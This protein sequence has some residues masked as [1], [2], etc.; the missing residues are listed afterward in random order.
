MLSFVKKFVYNNGSRKSIFGG[1]TMHYHTII[2][3]A[4]PAG[5]FAAQ[6]LGQNRKSVLI[7]E[8][9]P[10]AGRK[11]LISGAGQCNFTHAGPIEDFLMCY[12]DQGKF[13]KKALYSWTNLDTMRF[14]EEMNVPYQIYPNQ[15][16]FPKS[17]K[18][19]EVL[20]A[21]LRACQMGNV[22]IEY[23][24]T[25]TQLEVYDGIFA[26][27]TQEGKRY[28][29][30]HVILATGGK[31]YAQLGSDGLGYELAK[32]LGHTVISPHPALTD[33]RL[34]ASPYK[35]I[36]GIAVQN[37]ALTIWRDQ[38]K[39]YSNV[40]DLL[41]THKGISGPVIINSSRWMKENDSLTINLLHPST[42]EEI[43]DYF[44]NCL[45]QRGKEEVITFLKTLKL[46]KN[47]LQILCQQINLDEHTPCAQVNRKTR[48][49]LVTILTKCP[50]KVDQLGGFH[51]A[52]VTAGGVH[53][54]EVNPTTMESRKQKGLY[55]VGE[56]LDVD[57]IT[58]GYNI[59]AAFSTAYLCAKHLIDK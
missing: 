25:V 11:L 3:G 18:S 39:V 44:S 23:E 32:R 10:R 21:L 31:S 38:K 51:I 47:L 5:L 4:G 24:Q 26:I 46:P 27:E 22:T 7:L 49:A 58:G 6:M 15:K 36:S 9:N 34:N 45:A 52:M 35:S 13:I 14:F 41:F 54:K 29:S 40:G 56:V 28:F 53:L 48:E 33:V 2:I 20:A 12:H 17:M 37:V 42:Y 57:G 1:N 43:K 50:F 16:V 19:E 59:Q 30:D 8:R 55:F